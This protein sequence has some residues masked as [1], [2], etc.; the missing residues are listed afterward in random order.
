MVAET[1][2]AIGLAGNIV[3]FLDF[4]VKL[5]KQ[6]HDIYRS[7]LG[8]SD[9]IVDAEIAIKDLMHATQRLRISLHPPETSSTLTAA[10]TS[11][12]ELRQRCFETGQEFLKLLNKLTIKGHCTRWKSIK[13]ALAKEWKDG[14]FKELERWLTGLREEMH[15]HVTVTL[16]EQ[17]DLVAIR[18]AETF[19]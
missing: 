4:S 15:F 18:Q 6:S 2:A 5:L 10:E 13:L 12:D 17:I 9:D 7:T 8:A 16:R 19:Q 11:L 3:Q 14:T 1:L